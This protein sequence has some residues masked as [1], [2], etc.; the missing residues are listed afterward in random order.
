MRLGKQSIAFDNVYVGEAAVAAG[1][2]EKLGPLG[3]YFD[4]GYT[5]FVRDEKT[6][7]GGD[8]IVA[9]R[10]RTVPRKNNIGSG[11]SIASSAAI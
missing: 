3:A 2:K 11:G 10:G 1:P 9:R 7:E 5:I 8:E 6:G 4:R